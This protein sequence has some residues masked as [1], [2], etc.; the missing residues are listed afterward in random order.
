MM[1]QGRTPSF[2]T[3][4]SSSPMEHVSVVSCSRSSRRFDMAGEPCVRGVRDRPEEK[5]NGGPRDACWRSHRCHRVCA[6]RAARHRGQLR[7]ATAEELRSHVGR[8]RR[9]RARRPM[10]AAGQGEQSARDDGGGGGGRR[11]RARGGEGHGATD[12]ARGAVGAG[13]GALARDGE[14]PSRFASATSAASSRR[15]RKPP[16]RSP[17]RSARTCSPAATTTAASTTRAS[18][19]AS[20][21]TT[22]GSRRGRAS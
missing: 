10:A 2:V 4:A 20:S 1:R 3:R 6:R 7:R 13:R 16:R 9:V 19:R 5:I 15:A 14:V 12:R 8:H 17:T 22:S 11:Q 18:A 21:R